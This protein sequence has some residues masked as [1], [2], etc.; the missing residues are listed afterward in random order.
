MV[1]GFIFMAMAGPVIAGKHYE[2]KNLKAGADGFRHLVGEDLTGLL[3]NRTL[4]FIHKRAKHIK[5]FM[6]H[7]QNGDQYIKILGVDK[8]KGKVFKK[9]YQIRDGVLHGNSIVT[10]EA[11][12]TR[13]YGNDDGLVWNCG[14]TKGGCKYNSEE[15]WDG[16]PQNLKK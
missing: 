4:L 15:S 6:F 13:F 9:S 16:D 3:V 12:T 14:G 8:Y 10:N 11:I 5:I 2:E 7:H 1:A